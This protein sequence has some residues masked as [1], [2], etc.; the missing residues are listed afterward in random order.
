MQSHS[1]TIRLALCF[2]LLLGAL[3]LVIWRQSNAL[4]TLRELD[5]LRDARALAEAER[6][7]LLRRI[8]RLESRAFVVAAA[9]ERLGMRVP[10]AHEIVFLPR[11]A[12]PAVPQAQRGNNI[13]LGGQP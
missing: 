1:G 13:A 4:A 10:A 7:E 9:R 3:A 2:A 5:D 11:P 8:E 6:S 12:E